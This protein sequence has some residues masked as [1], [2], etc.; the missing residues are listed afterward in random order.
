MPAQPLARRPR[1]RPFRLAVAAGVGAIL[2]VVSGCGSG[3]GPSAGASGAATTGEAASAAPSSARPSSPATI[4]IVTPTQGQLVTGRSVHVVVAV[5]HAQVVQATTTAVRPD[6]GHV[7][8]YLDNTLVYMNYTLSQDLPVQPGTYVLKAEF[9]ASDH[10]PFSP[11]VWSEQ[12][13]FTVQ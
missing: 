13:L 1:P 7:H 12:V 8:L 2:L 4:R 10:A 5:D 9:V 11:R 3:A 6:Q